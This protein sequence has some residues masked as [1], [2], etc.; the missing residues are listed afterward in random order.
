MKTRSPSQRKP[1]KK[2]F[3]SPRQVAVLVGHH[4]VLW[5]PKHPLYRNVTATEAAWQDIS[6]HF[7]GTLSAENCKIEWQSVRRI[8]CTYY[9][10][11]L[12]KAASGSQAKRKPREFK[13]AKETS[14]LDEINIRKDE[15]LGNL[16]HLSEEDDDDDTGGDS[17]S[18]NS[19]TGSETDFPVSEDE[20][21]GNHKSAM[22]FSNEMAELSNDEREKFRFDKLNKAFTGS[23]SEVGSTQHINEP[24]RSPLKDVNGRKIERKPP[25]FE[26]KPHEIKVK[27]KASVKENNKTKKQRL[28]SLKW[29]Y[30]EGD[31]FDEDDEVAVDEGCEKPKKRG[32]SKLQVKMEEQDTKLEN[33]KKLRAEIA[34]QVREKQIEM[35]TALAKRRK[36]APY[37]EHVPDRKQTYHFKKSVIEQPDS[38]FL[39]SLAESIMPK[40]EEDPLNLFFMSLAARCKNLPEL[41]IDSLVH[42][43]W[44]QISEARQNVSKKNQDFVYPTLNSEMQQ[45]INASFEID[46]NDVIVHFNDLHIRGCDFQTLKPATWLNDMIID[47]YM[48]LVSQTSGQTSGKLTLAVTCH[49]I[50]S[51]IAHG[52]AGHKGTIKSKEEIEVFDFLLVPFCTNSH[53]TLIIV[54]VKRR[55]M[56]V[57]DSLEKEHHGVLQLVKLYFSG[58]WTTVHAEGIPRQNNGYDCGIFICMYAKHFCLGNGFQF[59]QEAMPHLRSLLAYELL[60]TKLLPL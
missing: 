56:T 32:K 55:V 46:P 48:G 14:F 43:F 44:K 26:K 60:T 30:T 31:M 34:Q 28:K 3:A 39:K 11:K 27:P 42:D 29:N 22:D 33:R 54:D 58:D 13:Y 18:D 21:G 24:F 2:D 8:R 9:N 38:D 37:H 5:D 45:L 59:G 4:P 16:E 25:M 20:V 23:Q 47:C 12:K 19:E 41:V 50:T 17:D 51:L 6:K 10:T 35:E 7:K 1:P 53:W 49:F 52:I 40:E 57:Y 15:Q 36:T